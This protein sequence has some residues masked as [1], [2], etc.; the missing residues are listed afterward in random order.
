MTISMT[1]QTFAAEDDLYLEDDDEIFTDEDKDWEESEETDDPE[2]EWDEEDDQ[3]LVDVVSDDDYSEDDNPDAEYSYEFD[4]E[5]TVLKEYE[6]SEET[7]S[8]TL[9]VSENQYETDAKSKTETRR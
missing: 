7:Y 2:D 3:Y 1:A 5:D 4:E 6:L 8:Q 9:D